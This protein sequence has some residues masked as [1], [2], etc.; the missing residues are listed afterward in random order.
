MNKPEKK[1]RAGAI[2]ATIWKNAGEK[3]GSEYAFNTITLSRSYKD[4]AGQWKTSGSL[5]LTDLPRAALVLNKAYEH[6]VISDAVS[7]T[8]IEED[9]LD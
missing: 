2:S 9:V 6:L 1:F 5:R 4:K 8:V 3:N 7:P